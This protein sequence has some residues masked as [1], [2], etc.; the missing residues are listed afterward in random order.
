M[1]SSVQLFVF[2]LKAPTRTLAAG[3]KRKSVMY[4]KKGTV[5]I[6]ASGKRLRPVLMPGRSA[7]VAACVAMAASYAPTFEGH[8]WAISAFAFVCCPEL[9]NLTCE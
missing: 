6:H 3:R 9:A 7:S 4:A 1:L 8:C 2:D 5:A